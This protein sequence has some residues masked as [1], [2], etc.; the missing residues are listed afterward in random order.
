MFSPSSACAPIHNSAHDRSPSDDV[1]RLKKKP[2]RNSGFF[3]GRYPSPAPSSAVHSRRLSGNV[4]AES[5]SGAA[6]TLASAPEVVRPRRKS[7]QQRKRPSVFGSLRSLHSLEDDEKSMGRSRGSGDDDEL[8]SARTGVG[9]AILH[10]G[11]V[12]TTG[13]M[14]RKRS[15]YLVLTESHLVRFKSLGKAIDMFPSIYASCGRSTPS[16]RQSIASISSLQDAQLPSH[17]DSAVGIPLNSI[18]AVY[19]LD[20]GRPSSTVE[21][22]YL[23][24]RTRKAALIQMQTADLEELNLWMVGIRSAAEMA[25]SADPSTS[26][27]RSVEHVARVLELERDYDPETLR[28]FRVIQMA[29]SKSLGRASSDDL[30]KLSPTGFYLAIGSHKVHLIPM[31]KMA[32]RSSA[33]SLNDMETTVS[34]GLMTLTGLSMEWGDDSL[35]LTFR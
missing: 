4:D 17:G 18:I 6:S 35:H 33:V 20:D 14:W 31:Q 28:M 9:S 23:D 16:N 25:R 22:A 34:F 8:S 29:S 2:R 5:V 10:H 11:E 19:M 15:Q 12:Q 21:V 13:S 32:N 1:Q 7:L 26:D 3:G 30:A 27:T 24:D